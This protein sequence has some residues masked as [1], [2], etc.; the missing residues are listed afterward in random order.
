LTVYLGT[1]V[2]GSLN[3]FLCFGFIEEIF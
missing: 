2:S 1:V 3:L